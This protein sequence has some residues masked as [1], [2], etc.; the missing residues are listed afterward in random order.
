MKKLLT[1]LLLSLAVAAQA[2][3]QP[4][5]NV[6]NEA[7]QLMVNYVP[8]GEN[9]L[10]YKAYQITPDSFLSSLQAYKAEAYAL[11]DRSDLTTGDKSLAKKDIGYY[12]LSRL[13]NYWLYYGAD[14]VKYA[15]FI[16]MLETRKV[17]GASIDSARKASYLKVF[18]PAQRSLIDSLCSK[19]IDLNDSA[20]FVYSRTYRTYLSDWVG[21][22]IYSEFRNELTGWSDLSVLKLKVVNR[23]IRDP[24][25]H[26]YLAHS[27]TGM[28]IKTSKDST[29]KDSVYRAFMA[30]ATKPAYRSNIDSIYT[31][32]IA[33]GA[34]R[35]APDFTYTAVNGKKVSLKSLRGRY[36][37]IDVWATWCAPCKKEIPF[38]MEVEKK[39]KGKNIQFISL[40]VDVPKDREKWRKYVLDNHLEGL[41][42]I[43]E[44]GFESDFIKKFNIASIPRFIL[45]DPDGKI[46]SADAKRPSD[47]ALQKQ[48]DGL[49]GR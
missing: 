18:T 32:Y 46:V 19:A 9:G 16:K 13:Y 10:L 17:T 15:A 14:S 7:R 25:I 43:T 5:P 31:N 6:L 41:Q 47:G 23:R 33:F 20:L 28:I 8:V 37:Y 22:M 44:N 35:P 38:L 48:L 49:L 26:D 42:L 39:Y 21:R 1:G 30:T 27:L 12:A 11:I 2:Q 45:I 4:E 3:L 24:Y 34:N 36:I 40:S 29:L